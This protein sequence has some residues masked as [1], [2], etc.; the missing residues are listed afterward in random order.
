MSHAKRPI[1]VY[2][3]L[4]V[5]TKHTECEFLVISLKILQILHHINYITINPVLFDPFIIITEIYST[6]TNTKFDSGKC[7]SL[8]GASPNQ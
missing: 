8:P 2:S 5:A 3:I 4:C 7:Y 6:F 1:R